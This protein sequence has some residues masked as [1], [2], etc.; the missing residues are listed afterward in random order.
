LWF[1][2]HP[3]FG[4]HANY[5]QFV[6]GDQ[7]SWSRGKHTFR[8][9]FETERVQG[10]VVSG[11]QS[12]GQPAFQSFADFLIGRAGCSGAVSPS[13]ANRDG[14]NGSATS[15]VQ[16]VGGTTTA[17]A[18]VQVNPR[19]LMFNSFAQD[20][21]KLTPRFTLNLGMR[22]EL[23]N[24]PTENNGNYSSFWSV[25][26]QAGPVPVVAS[27]TPGAA[28]CLGESLAG[29]VLP[30]NYTGVIPAGVFQSSLPYATRQK[31][32]W[33]NF[34]P[35]IGF[36]WQ[37]TSSNRL[38]LRG[39]AGYFYDQ[40]SGQYTANFGRANPVF[41]PPASGSPAASLQNP[42]AIPGGVVSVGTGYFGFVP[43][44]II[45]GNCATANPCAGGSSS[46]TGVTSYEDLT[47]PLTYEWNVNT[48]WEF[49]P[50]WVLEVGYV[51]SHG[52]HQASPQAVQN[53]TADGSPGNY[54]YNAAQL[55]GGGPCP[56]CALNGVT[57]N[58]PANAFLRVPDL[59]ISA[60]AGRLQTISNYKYNSLQVTVR[61]QLSKGLQIQAAY[62]FNR[63]FEQVEQGA[64]TYPYII[65]AYAPEYFV[66]PQRLVVNYVW[67]LPLGKHNGALG[68]LASGWSW[69]GVTVI[70]N[71]QPIDI[72]DSG[73]GAIF[74][75]GPVAGSLG[76][77]QLC[78][79]KT[80]ADI[81]TSGS[82]TQRVTNGLSG[83]DGWIN[84]SVF[85]PV[86]SAGAINGQGGG[87]GFGNMG[88][89]NVLG[90]GQS[91][92]D[93]S[94][95]KLFKIRES[96]NLQF[97]TEFY[98]TFNHPQFGNLDGSDVQNGVGMGSITKT[99]VNP[100]VIQFA[101]KYLF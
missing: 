97:R 101:L 34:A 1:G 85:C 73:G 71:G 24:W 7:V 11:T 98:N 62:S 93:M 35:R 46:S 5:N 44:W 100:R 72:V 49:L 25:L 47:V 54:H 30:S 45:P 8:F 55:V 50:S 39:G 63:G 60:T 3:F 41:G 38:V 42:W 90:P 27:C 32:P 83:L 67:E 15:N 79:G 29:Y 53:P 12:V 2:V 17:N 69:S 6:I 28:T 13:V 48:Q 91:N 52:I 78:P 59:G 4:S 56:S 57:I 82:T 75:L 87:S 99:S 58:T 80:A 74:G 95:A 10:A 19:Y 94:L 26:A 36:A 68:V 37:P 81:L 92:W 66:R 21:I 31:A 64:N 43:R 65:Q 9:G 40:L 20:D 77:A 96:Q 88:F 86:P 61:K 16:S 76:P 22:W 14:C 33:D 70:Q 18:A 51:G 84:S 23:D 89:G